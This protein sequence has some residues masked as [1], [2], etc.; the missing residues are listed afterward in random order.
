MELLTSAGRSLGV[1]LRRRL[2]TRIEGTAAEP[3]KPGVIVLT[4][5]LD[6]LST[7]ESAHE[8]I[9]A[10]PAAGMFA[11]WDMLPAAV[12]PV[13][14]LARSRDSAAGAHALERAVDG[15][16]LMIEAAPLEGDGAGY[17]AVTL[18][19][20]TPK[21]TFDILARAHALT[22]RE[23]DVVT[24]V[25]AGLDTNAITQQLLISRHT[26]QDHLKSIFE[27]IG[28]HSRRELLT[29][30][31]APRTLAHRSGLLLDH[32]AVFWSEDVA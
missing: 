10:L 23:R 9:D 28:V 32:G 15:R 24:A 22:R 7:T 4:P 5:E 13:A 26:V 6:V 11:T 16:W 18:R 30:F 3:S 25:C 12:Y 8:W 19:N 31:N 2:T 17:V 1:V 27:K 21:E 29:T 20:A 14:T